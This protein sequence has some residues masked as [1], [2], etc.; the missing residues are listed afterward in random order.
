MNMPNL[1]LIGAGGHSHSCIDVI[2]QEEKFRIA[3]LIGRPEEL[4]DKHLGYT[5]IGSDAD[6]TQLVKDY[7]YAL[8]TIGQIR[9]PETRRNLFNQVLE[10]GFQLPIVISPT[11]Y[12]SP[13]ASIGDGTVIM[14][15]ATIN[16][17]SKVGRNCIINSHALI[18]H[19]SI[20]EDHCHLSTGAILNGDVVVGMGSFIGSGSVVREGVTIGKHC[21]V[22]IGLVVRHNQS[23]D[24]QYL[25]G[26][27]G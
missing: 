7:Q 24:Q 25:G 2:E 19:D 12:V 16:A 3:G 5:V 21:F 18:E 26:Q 20:M 9:S 8:V 11:A 6:L 14:H 27:S 1:L 15:G 10:I 23:D 17:G 22:G 13:H 4:N